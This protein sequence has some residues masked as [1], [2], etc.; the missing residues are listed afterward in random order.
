MA[1]Y[2][3]TYIDNDASRLNPMAG[4]IITIVLLTA[5][6]SLRAAI[7]P[8][9]IVLAT[10]PWQFRPDGGVGHVLLCHHQRAWWSI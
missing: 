10:V 5:F 3:S 2:L 7:L 9:I 8:N 6:V 1:G 4:L